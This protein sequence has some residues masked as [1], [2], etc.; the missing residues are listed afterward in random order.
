M[1]K[2]L[3]KK[4]LDAT[5][6]ME[7]ANPQSLI[8]TK[9]IIK[10]SG[11]E[12]KKA[13]KDVEKKMKDYT[14]AEGE[15]EN[16]DV[17]KKYNYDKEQK[18]LHDIGELQKGSIINTKIK[19]ETEEYKE[20]QK[21]AIEG[22]STMGNAKEGNAKE[23]NVANVV[24][25]DQAGFKGPDGDKETYKNS[26]KFKE[27]RDDVEAVY[28]TPNLAIRGADFSDAQIEK[29]AKQDK[30]EEEKVNEGMKRLVFKKEFNGVENALKLIPESYR[31]D[32]KTFQ[33]TDGN[34]NYEIRWEGDINEG[35]A[36]V[37]K[38]S[39][40]ELMNEDMQKMKH[41]MG[42]NSK[43]TLGNLKGADRIN[44]NNSFN[45]IWGKTKTLINEMAGEV[46]Q[47]DIDWDDE[48]VKKRLKAVKNI[49]EINEPKNKWYTLALDDMD[50]IKGLEMTFD[51]WTLTL[52]KA[53]EKEKDE[54]LLGL[55]KKLRFDLL[56]DK[57]IN[58]MAGEDLELKSLAKK[59]IPILKK[60]GMKVDYETD[61]K[62][63]EMKPKEG[64]QGVPAKLLIRK[65]DDGKGNQF[66]MLTVGVYWLELARAKNDKRLGLQELDMGQG[67]SAQTY[68]DADEMANKMYK[69]LMAVVPKDKFDSQSQS[70]MNRWGNYLIHFKLKSVS[71]G[72]MWDRD[73]AHSDTTDNTYYQDNWD[74]MRQQGE[75]YTVFVEKNGETIEYAKYNNEESAE[76]DV[77]KLNAIGVKAYY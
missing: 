28:T 27:K 46:L 35:R 48:E 18:E 8:A 19:N 20:R 55:L 66:G 43:D 40:K 30:E 54:Q 24:P 36:I 77:Q 68:E 26:E 47:E 12:N 1:N 33:M 57:S 51:T 44:E 61:T 75:E 7:E 41:L 37:I 21:M 29:L 76:H 32:N 58:E 71:E 22:D 63:L 42:Y 31:V 38:A 15:E 13:M 3:I 6:L 14:K 10:D 60:Y 39:D 17:V 69:E 70:K 5:F 74:E 53:A 9:K 64:P 45:D 16:K 56:D 34:E 52:K 50:D 59:F 4:Y 62:A 65:Q 25:S 67:P 72:E 11:K 73:A 49:L 2:S 23:G